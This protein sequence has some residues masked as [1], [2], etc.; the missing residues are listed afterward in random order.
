VNFFNLGIFGSK[1]LEFF[2]I[3]CV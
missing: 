2:K 3:E 1:I